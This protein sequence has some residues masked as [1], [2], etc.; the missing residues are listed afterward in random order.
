[1]Q[2]RLLGWTIL[3]A[4]TGMIVGSVAIAP[5]VAP[6]FV[7]LTFACVW[8][9][10][11]I[12]TMAKNRE[13]CAITGALPMGSREALRTGLLVGIVGGIIAS[14]I[15]VGVEMTLYTV[16]VLMYRCDLKVAVPTAVSAMAAIS[17][18]G[19][20]THLALGDI[21]RDVALKFLAAGPVVI[22]GAPIGTY[23]L[24]VIPRVRALY[25]ISVLCVLQFVWTLYSLERSLAEWTF[26]VA[27]MSLAGAVFFGMYRR[28][29]RAA[30]SRDA[31]A[32]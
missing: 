18:L 32:S 12:L 22:F 24:S 20:A 31:A 30:A 16:L 19:A 7:K 13:V 5:Q 23:I 4:A 10:F 26:V 8:M 27:A 2:A 15:G 3:G 29:R 17:I 21:S 9:S 28:G 11:A 25:V 6:N 14:V 1:M